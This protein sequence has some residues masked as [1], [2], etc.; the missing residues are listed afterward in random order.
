MKKLILALT[1]FLASC[2]FTFKNTQAEELVAGDFKLYLREMPV[3]CGHYN[4]VI[5]YLMY[6]NFT[7]HNKSVGKSGA[8]KEGQRVFAI[9]YY[10]NTDKTESV[11]VIGIPGDAELCMMYRTFELEE[12]NVED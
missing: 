6:Y 2:T 12:F 11:A 10:L 3:M 8:V 5:S 1:I 9:V 7:P 4:D